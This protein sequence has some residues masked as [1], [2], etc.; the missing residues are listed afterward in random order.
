LALC[1]RATHPG[2]K[3]VQTNFIV[4]V[5]G[6][7][8]QTEWSRMLGA[9]GFEEREIKGVVEKMIS[10]A[11]EAFDATL[12]VRS[13]AREALG[14]EEAGISPHPSQRDRPPAHSRGLA[15]H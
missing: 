6:S 1:A 14:G 2:Y 12:S 4:G 3:I 10:A 8:V 13:A 5:L 11:V 7:V 15:A 9:L